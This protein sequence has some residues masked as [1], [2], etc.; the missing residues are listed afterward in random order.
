MKQIVND[1]RYKYV[2]SGL[3]YARGYY[4]KDPLRKYEGLYLLIM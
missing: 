4:V 3:S 2:G 1:V